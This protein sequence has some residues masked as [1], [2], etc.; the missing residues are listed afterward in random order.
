MATN[1]DKA[2]MLP[3]VEQVVNKIFNN[4]VDA[5]Y[6]GRAMDMLFDGVTVDCSSDETL[7]VGA[8]M[9]FEDSSSFVKKDDTHLLFSLF[10]GVSS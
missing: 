1:V 2:A 9:T 8:C 3:A 7:V 6:T 10:G 5:F 4:P